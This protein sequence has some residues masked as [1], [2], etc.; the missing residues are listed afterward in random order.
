MTWIVVR[1]MPG[2]ESKA[3]LHVERGHGE[4]YLP[5]FRQARVVCHRRVLRMQV[6]FPGYLFVAAMEH[7]HWLLGTIGIRGLLMN[8]ER[9][10]IITN[11]EVNRLKSAHDEDGFVVLPGR[12]DISRFVPDEPV[13]AINGPFRDLIGLHE[14]LGPHGRCQILFDMLGRKV[15]VAIP[16]EDL[17]SAA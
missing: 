10:G 8:G 15:R 2:A 7:W 9:P 13:R 14:G 5:R 17:V 12:P 4:C 6:L 11:E 16:E 1:T 3:L